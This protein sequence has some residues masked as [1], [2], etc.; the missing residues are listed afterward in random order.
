[1]KNT[2]SRS[3]RGAG[4]SQRQLKVAETLR[5]QLFIILRSWHDEDHAIE[6]R[7]LT[8]SQIRVSSDL[9]HAQVFVAALGGDL[10][11]QLAAAGGMEALLAT[12]N[13]AAPHF[14]KQLG[15]RIHMKFTPR[16]HFYGDDSYDQ[17]QLIEKKLRDIAHEDVQRQAHQQMQQGEA[18]ELEEVDQPIQNSEPNTDK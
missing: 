4:P 12:L 11:S 7:Q 15:R 16:L 2:P 10:G 8:I 13:K 5:Q 17:A 6:G 14:Q 18:E 9:R 1:M 3:S